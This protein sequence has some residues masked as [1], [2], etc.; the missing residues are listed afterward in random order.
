MIQKFNRN[1]GCRDIDRKIFEYIANKF[2]QSKGLDI[3]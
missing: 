3:K 1:L 2:L